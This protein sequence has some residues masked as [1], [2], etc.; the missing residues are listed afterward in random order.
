MV[1]EHQTER[2]SLKAS[3][4][5]LLRCWVIFPLTCLSNTM[6]RK[7]WKKHAMVVAFAQNRTKILWI[8]T[9]LD[10]SMFKN[11]YGK[12]GLMGANYQVL[13]HQHSLFWIKIS[14]QNATFRKQ[15]QKCTNYRRVIQLSS[16]RQEN[17]C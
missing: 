7:T 13:F 14:I 15:T 11:E 4:S 16:E 17:M 3:S 1:I 6:K 12:W 9:V 10:I 8:R 5:S 2:E